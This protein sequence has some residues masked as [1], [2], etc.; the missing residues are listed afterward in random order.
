MSIAVALLS[1]PRGDQLSEGDGFSR[2]VVDHNLGMPVLGGKLQEELAAGAAGHTAPAAAR[3]CIAEGN[4]AADDGLPT[5]HVHIEGGD[6]LG[7]E[8]HHAAA[9]L[10]AEPGVNVSVFTLQRAHDVMRVHKRRHVFGVVLRFCG[11]AE[12]LPDVHGGSF[13]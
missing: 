7:A 3:R 12:P 8:V 11:F 6:A 10:D 1:P 4:Q 13:R 9:A 5:V 2:V